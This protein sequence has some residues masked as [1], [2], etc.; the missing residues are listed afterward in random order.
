M[1]SFWHVFA[2]G[3]RMDQQAKTRGTGAFPKT[4]PWGRCRVRPD[5]GGPA[6][7]WSTARAPVRNTDG[8]RRYRG[9][10]NLSA[11]TDEAW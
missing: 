10:Y 8:V 5:S 4:K 1:N 2:A 11:D 7:E 3:W 6:A 9:F